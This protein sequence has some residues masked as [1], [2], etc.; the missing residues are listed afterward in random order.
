MQVISKYNT[1]GCPKNQNKCWYKTGSPPPIGSKNVVLKLRSVN[2]IVIPPAKT[3]NDKSKRKAVTKTPQT[4]KGSS[5]N[6]IEGKRILNIVVIKFKAPNKEE[7]PAKCKL[8]IAKSTA[9][10]ECAVIELNGG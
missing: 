10:P 2:N 9:G 1:S 4:N 8:K 5:V 3:G 6:T 7:I